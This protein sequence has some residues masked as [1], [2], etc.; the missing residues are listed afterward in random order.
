MLYLRQL[1]VSL[2]VNLKAVK[3]QV[4]KSHSEFTELFQKYFY[5]DSRGL[6]GENTYL[7]EMCAR[8]MG[9]V[10]FVLHGKKKRNHP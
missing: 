10:P 5:S 1:T 6:Y 7:I 3:G 9:C 2:L 4:T 8:K